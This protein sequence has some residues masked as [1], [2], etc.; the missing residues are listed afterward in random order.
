[1]MQFDLN[2]FCDYAVHLCDHT[3][4]KLG[5]SWNNDRSCCCYIKEI[6]PVAAVVVAVAIAIHAEQHNSGTSLCNKSNWAKR[7]RV[8]NCLVNLMDDFVRKS[9]PV[10]WLKQASGISEGKGL[11]RLAIL[12]SVGALCQRTRWALLQ[13]T[14]RQRGAKLGTVT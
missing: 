13:A 4:A 10:S 9:L 6:T 1:M 8:L 7:L 2:F 3:A 5:C 12:D 14:N 11:G